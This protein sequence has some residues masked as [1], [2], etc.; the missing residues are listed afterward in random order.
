[1]EAALLFSSRLYEQWSERH[2]RRG[3][4][5]AAVV[6]AWSR[7]F[8]LRYNEL[9]S[10]NWVE[11]GV[12]VCRNRCLHKECWGLSTWTVLAKT[13]RTNYRWAKRLPRFRT[14][15]HAAL[16]WPAAHRLNISVLFQLKDALMPLFHVSCVRRSHLVCVPQCK[17]LEQLTPTSSGVKLITHDALLT[18]ASC[19]GLT[20]QENLD[21]GFS[22]FKHTRVDAFLDCTEWLIVWCQDGSA[23]SSVNLGFRLPAGVNWWTAA[24]LCEEAGWLHFSPTESR[25]I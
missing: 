20:V 19:V 18:E 3:E 15:S 8:S 6:G 9:S 22:P 13:N 11:K 12:R 10:V 21:H 17:A 14:W 7:L 4:G 24:A 2:Q 5:G 23:D 25:P 1:M 16:A